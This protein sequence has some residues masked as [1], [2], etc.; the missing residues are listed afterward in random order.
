MITR[1][2]E[3]LGNHGAL[4]EIVGWQLAHGGERA[5]IE[6]ARAMGRNGDRADLL[7]PGLRHPNHDVVLAS[8]QA[9]Q[10]VQ[11]RSSDADWW[12]LIEPLTASSNPKV[13]A[14]ARELLRDTEPPPPARSDPRLDTATQQIQSGAE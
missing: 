4:Q 2:D 13:A 10:G 7:A 8:I 6:A 12:S 11:R 14:L 5:A 9:V 3:R 1:W